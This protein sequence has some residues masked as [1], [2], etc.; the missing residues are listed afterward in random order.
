MEKTKLELQGAL[1]QKQDALNA[2]QDA[3]DGQKRQFSVSARIAASRSD[4]EYGAGNVRDSLNWML[5]ACELAPR[6][7]SLRPSYIC[8]VGAR[9]RGLSDHALRHDGQVWTASFSPD[10]RTVL[11]ASD[12]K[13]AR[14]W[15]AATGMVL[16][17]LTHEDTVGSV[18][19]SPDGRT[20]V[21]VSGRTAWLWD[22]ATGKELQRLTHEGRV[23]D[24]SFS[25]DGRT[26]LTLSDKTARL[27]DAASGKEL[28]QLKHNTQVYAA[29]FSPDGRAVVTSSVDNT[30]RLWDATSGK[31]L[32]RLA[33][34][35]TARVQ[36]RRPHGRHHQP[37]QDGPAVGRRQRQGIATPHA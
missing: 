12:D 19:F 27:W 20:V 30:A 33:G 6:E 29:S 4:A 22:A 21:T 15:D 31:E 32:L 37:G 36:P 10:G 13:T 17:R 18:S 34:W 14:L 16:Q 2:K 5:Q 35:G 23:D 24:A 26:V 8:R 9:G 1:H 3:L 11:T 25:P 7:D 28:Q